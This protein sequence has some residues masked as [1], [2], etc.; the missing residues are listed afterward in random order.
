MGPAKVT[1]KAVRSSVM[2]A[3]DYRERAQQSRQTDL[4][5]DAREQAGKPPQNSIT[6]CCILFQKTR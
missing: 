1:A 6:D 2:T 4:E 3:K 5:V